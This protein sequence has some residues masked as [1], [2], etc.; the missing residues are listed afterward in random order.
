MLWK[1][2]LQPPPC[3]TSP[4]VSMGGGRGLSRWNSLGGLLCVGETVRGRSRG[5]AEPRAGE[6]LERPEREGQRDPEGLFAEKLKF[7]NEAGEA[8]KASEASGRGQRLGDSG[9]GPER[10]RWSRLD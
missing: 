3:T 1:K 10:P 7:R 9:R 5:Q 2:A 4:G 8:Q 6:E